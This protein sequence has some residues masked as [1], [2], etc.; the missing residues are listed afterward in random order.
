[1]LFQ[2]PIGTN[3]TRLSDHEGEAIKRFQSPIGTNKTLK[4][5][6]TISVRDFRFNPLQVQ[7]KRQ[8]YLGKLKGGQ[9]FQSPIGTNKTGVLGISE[10]SVRFKFQSPIG[11]N[12][13]KLLKE[14]KS[15]C[16]V[17]SIPYRY[18]QNR[19][20]SCCAIVASWRFQSPIGTNKTN[21]KNFFSIFCACVSIPYRYK[22]NP[23]ANMLNHERLK[24][25][26]PIGT[27]KTFQ[28]KTELSVVSK[29]FNP[30]QVQTKQTLLLIENPVT[31]SF[32]PLQVQTKQ[33]ALNT[34]KTFKI[35]FN[36]LQVQTKPA[37]SG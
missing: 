15:F 16:R 10:V 29:C 36:P 21:A 23:Y 35:S 2:S 25:Q 27:N 30:L 5:V 34:I 3:K 6:G 33:T 12:K 28:T 24:F 32:N 8:K 7:T 20:S 31:Q 4:L 19:C 1:M 11:T 37:P 26:S 9:A 22:Q 14:S 18:K 13:T 17:V